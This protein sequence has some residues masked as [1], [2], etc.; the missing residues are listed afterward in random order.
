MVLQA[1]LVSL[2][3]GLVQGQ[4]GRGGVEEGREQACSL[5]VAVDQTAW[6]LLGGRD[7]EVV[8]RVE[9]FVEELNKIYLSTILEKPPHQG[10]YFRCT[11]SCTCIRTC[12]CT[13]NYT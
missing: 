3:V 12:T 5:L 10:I 11:C 13:C 1:T 2:V 4:G 7:G 8:R 9:R 6:P